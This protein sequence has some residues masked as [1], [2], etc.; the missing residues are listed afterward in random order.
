ME[1]TLLTDRKT[2]NFKIDSMK[3]RMLL[4]GPDEIGYTLQLEDW[5]TDYEKRYDS[6]SFDGSQRNLFKVRN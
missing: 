4:E 1:Q 5:I 3:R 6:D 2:M